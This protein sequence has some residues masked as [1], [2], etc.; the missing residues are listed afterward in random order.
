MPPPG[1]TSLPARPVVIGSG[2]G[3]LARRL[4]PRRAG[5]S[6]ARA[7][8]RPGRA[9]ADSRRATPSTRRAARSG[10]QLSVRR[11]GRRHVQRRQADLPR[12]RPRRAPSAARCSPSAKESR[13]SSTIIARTSAAIDCRPW[14]RRCASASKRMGGEFRFHC[15]VED[16]DLA[17]GSVRGLHTSSGYVP[18]T[19][20]SCWPI[21]HSARDTYEML[22]RRGVPMEQKPF[23]IGRAHRA[24][25]RGVNRVQ[26]GG[27][28]ARR[29]ARFGRLHA[30]GTAGRH[31]LFTFCMCAGGIRHAQRLRARLLLHQRHEPVETRFALRQ[32]R[33]GR[34]LAARASAARTS[35]LACCLQAHYEQTRLRAGPRRVS[36]SDPAGEGFLERPQKRR[37]AAVEL[38]ARRSSARCWPSWCRRWWPKRCVMGLPLMDRRWR[39]RFLAEAT[40]VGPEARGS[41]PVRILPRR[42]QPGIAR[43]RRPVS[44]GGRGR[45]RRRHRQRRRGRSAHRP[46]HRRQVRTPGCPVMPLR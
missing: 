28:P 9:R 34:H 11:R 30:R 23:Q 36:L 31:D 6:T 33:A 19:V 24:A 10:K 38:S 39:G 8:T 32:Q 27:G 13:R 15:R 26:Y 25:A 5:L 2:P 4:F 42:P 41:S 3:G 22:L 7:R 18:T 12:L 46:G 44:G 21:G 29:E 16:L 43:H 37:A 17:D 20:A 40:L 35:W 45:L 14:S 1:A